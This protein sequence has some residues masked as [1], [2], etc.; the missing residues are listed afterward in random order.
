MS[1]QNLSTN[2]ANISAGVGGQHSQSISFTPSAANAGH[3]HYF[4]YNVP[5]FTVGQ[6]L[7]TTLTKSDGTGTAAGA[8]HQHTHNSMNVATNTEESNMLHGHDAGSG[9]TNVYSEATHSHTVPSSNVSIP[10]SSAIDIPYINVL[11]FIKI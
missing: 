8:A 5:G 10:V 9:N 3:S 4:N 1:G 11:Y 7:G 2:A 6:A